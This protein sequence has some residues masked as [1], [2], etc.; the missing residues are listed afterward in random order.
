MPPVFFYFF[1]RYSFIPASG[2]INDLVG[3][4]IT[5]CFL[6][7]HS[8]PPFFFSPG[9][10]SIFFTI[11]SRSH[12]IPILSYTSRH[13]HPASNSFHIRKRTSEFPRKRSLAANPV[14][15]QSRRPCQL[16][17]QHRELSSPGYVFRCTVCNFTRTHSTPETPFSFV[18]ET[19]PGC[20]YMAFTNTLSLS[21]AIFF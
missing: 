20:K 10:T 15:L 21:S 9:T 19:R 18:L 2:S 5:V 8:S 16:P 13:F 11:P 12:T 1:I 6:F 14:C 7:L 3:H 4:S 17:I